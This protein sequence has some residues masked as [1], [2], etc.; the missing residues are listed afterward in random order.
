MNYQLIGQIVQK[1]RERV[2]N[3]KSPYYGSFYYRLTLELEQEK[4][5]K[6]ILAFQ[7]LVPTKI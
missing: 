5:T 6:E 7:N 1:Q 3:K 2:Y 4:K